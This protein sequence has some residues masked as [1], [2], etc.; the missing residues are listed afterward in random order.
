[1]IIDCISDLH[2][3]F[4]H[5]EG[6]D[7]LIVAG[8]VQRNHRLK[9]LM[10]FF[11]WLEVQPYRKKVLIAGNHDVCLE[12]TSYPFLK[13]CDYLQDSGTD[14]EGLKIWGS[15]WVRGNK[16]WSDNCKAFALENDAQLAEKWALIPDDTDILVTH[17]PPYGMM[18]E[19]EDGEPCGSPALTKWESDHV[20][21]LKLHVW[22]HIHEARGFYDVRKAKSK[23]GS[24]R[25]PVFVNAAI[26]DRCYKP[27]NKPIR[28]VL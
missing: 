28:V 17:S 20:S 22:G 1:M 7:L 14:F 8:D 19:T 13:I 25:I 11:D 5:M 23:L 24:P 2:G 26:M 18:D 3:T 21:T 27:V 15:P 4:P 12:E 9:C 10:E 6:G 16:W